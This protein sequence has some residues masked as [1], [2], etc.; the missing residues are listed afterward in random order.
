M[1]IRVYNK[2]IMKVITFTC[3]AGRDS[4][5]GLAT[6]YGQDGAGNESRGCE[7]FRSRPDRPW[8]PASCTIG[9]GCFQD[10]KRPERGVDHPTS[11]AEVKERVQLDLYSPSVPSRQVIGWH[12][13]LNIIQIVTLDWLWLHLSDSKN[14]A[15][16]IKHV[17]F[18]TYNLHL[19]ICTLENSRW[20]AE[21][22]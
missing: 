10:V 3:N 19:K 13:H 6:R 16:E 21:D 14:L 22:I 15:G 18:H 7:I 8:G 12:L 11:S 9:T 4:S 2:N 20:R 1:L 5:V 17:C